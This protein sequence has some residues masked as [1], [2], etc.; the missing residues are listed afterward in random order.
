MLGTLLLFSV[1][2]PDFPDAP[3]VRIS[4]WLVGIL[5]GL[6]AFFALFI[7]GA[8]VRTRKMKYNQVGENLIGQTGK[9]LTALSPVGTV[10]LTSETWSAVSSGEEEDRGGGEGGGGWGGWTYNQGP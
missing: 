1:G 4:L 9:V 10:Q 7:V 6:I 3:V 8:V 5:S 2:E